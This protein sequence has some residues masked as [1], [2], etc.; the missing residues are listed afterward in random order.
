MIVITITKTNK[1]NSNERYRQISM[2]VFILLSEIP[3]EMSTLS[4]QKITNTRSK[5]NGEKQPSIKCHD[6][7][8]Q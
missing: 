1:P 2:T 8:H 3:H 4:E 7:Q 5:A 6:N